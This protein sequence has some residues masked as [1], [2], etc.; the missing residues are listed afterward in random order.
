M[1]AWCW[2]R[3]Q[4]W[5]GAAPTSG[6]LMAPMRPGDRGSGCPWVLSSMEAGGEAEE[7]ESLKGELRPSPPEK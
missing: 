1:W 6:G 4:A 2:Q 7:G 3:S 5:E